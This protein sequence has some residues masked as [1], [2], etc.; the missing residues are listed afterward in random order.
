MPIK[1]V[2]MVFVIAVVLAFIY[3]EPLSRWLDKM[4]SEDNDINNKDHKEF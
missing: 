2:L 3:R 4:L 1:G